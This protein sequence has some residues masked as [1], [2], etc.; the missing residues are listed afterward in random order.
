[1]TFR[2]RGQSDVGGA[3]R[4]DWPFYVAFACVLV[5]LVL[6]VVSDARLGKALLALGALV[7]FVLS[8]FRRINPLEWVR[9]S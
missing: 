7:L 1:M 5:G 9:N 2:L 6:V 8:L 3:H 4:I